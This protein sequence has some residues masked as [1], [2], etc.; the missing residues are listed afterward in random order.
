M[1]Q[2]ATARRSSGQ[3]SKSNAAKK[4]T[5][6]NRSTGRSSTSSQSTGSR[7]SGTSRSDNTGS[8]S[9]RSGSA[10]G[11]DSGRSSAMRPSSGTM[12]RGV[13]SSSSGLSSPRSFQ[14]DS[15]QYLEKFFLDQLQDI[16]YAEQKIVQSL[17]KMQKAA[18]TDELK[19]AF[20]DHLY[21]TQRHVRRLEKIF[22]M[23]GQK[24]EGKKC[25]AIEGIV[26]EAE[27][28]IQETEENT[29]TRDAALIMAAQK[30]E[31]YEI[32]TYGGLVQMAIT[33]GQ[34]EVAE[35]LDR[36]LM[37]E[38]DTDLLLTEI[39][40]CEINVMAEFEGID[41]RQG[42]NE[43]EGSEEEEDQEGQ[44]EGSGMESEN[45]EENETR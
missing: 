5:A 1:K 20:E 28:I 18:T 12:E 43:E 21:Q 26:R 25:E 19:D 41:E 6:G 17:P 11:Q 44:Q 39:A 34:Y 2:T 16:Y 15:G 27:T 45:A 23:L 35:V 7:S 9:G 4:Q 36:T 42:E 40:E 13:S 31:H 32:A 37:E 24:A 10:K 33:M 14:P 30:V 29:M 8:R 38:E 3:R 22:E